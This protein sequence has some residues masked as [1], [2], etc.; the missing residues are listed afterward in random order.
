MIDENFDAKNFLKERHKIDICESVVK[1]YPDL[2]SEIYLKFYG[3][4][5]FDNLP[6]YNMS[7]QCGI[8]PQKRILN[9]SSNSYHELKV[10]GNKIILSGLR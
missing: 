4:A 3:V 6:E 8:F 9:R 1:D 5:Y 10:I 7:S 2:E